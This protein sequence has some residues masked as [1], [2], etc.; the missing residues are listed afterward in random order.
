MRPSYFLIE[1]RHVLFELFRWLNL[2]T[3]PRTLCRWRAMRSYTNSMTLAFNSGRVT[4]ECEKNLLSKYKVIFLKN[5]KAMIKHFN[6]YLSNV[7]ILKMNK[8]WLLCLQI[9]CWSHVLLTTVKSAC[10]LDQ[11][12][13][14]YSDKLM[15]LDFKRTKMISELAAKH[16]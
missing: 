7:Y 3:S 12:Q 16:R 4:Q 5:Y 2:S 11:I 9:F 1:R 15:Q 10:S 13:S 6:A 14:N 8:V